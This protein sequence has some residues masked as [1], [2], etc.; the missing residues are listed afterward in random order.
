MERRALLT[1][2][3]IGAAT[4]IGGC[5]SRADTSDDP[6]NDSGRNDGG[7]S[8][9]RIAA[10]ERGRRTVG[11]GSLRGDALRQPHAVALANR[12]AESVDATFAIRTA[13]GVA[14]EEPL[15]LGQDASIVVSLTEIARYEVEATVP[16]AGAAT[17]QTVDLGSFDCNGGQT[18]FAL[19]P[20]GRLESRTV[21]TMMACLDVVTERVAP[22]ESIERTIGGEPSSEEHGGADDEQHS[23]GVENPTASPWTVRVVLSESG[24]PRF[25][26]VFVLGAD[27]SANLPITEP[28]DYELHASVLETGESEQ[29]SVDPGRFDCN[30]STTN[31][32][33][34]EDGEL[35][36]RT[37]STLIA[38]DATATVDDEADGSR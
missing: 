25:D 12:T 4:A 7:N 9:D 20:D 29:E 13:D 8:G 26:G 14:F 27:A 15:E 11:D 37:I 36:I 2:L 1:T 16:D 38:C 24:D 22:G 17:T 21:S 23:L 28:G 3:G 32:I 33:A 34:T 30:A 10:G 19:Q 35:R 31:A 5:L 18:T 6:G